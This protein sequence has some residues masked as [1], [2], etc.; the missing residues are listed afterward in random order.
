V[1]VQKSK[2]LSGYRATIAVAMS[3]YIQAGSIIALATNLTV[4]QEAFGL[5]DERASPSTPV[6]VS[7]SLESPRS[8]LY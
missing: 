8:G 4:W 6:S 1:S 5:S 2:G 3:N 7:P